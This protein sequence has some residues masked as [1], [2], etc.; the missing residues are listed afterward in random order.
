MM[1]IVVSSS[2]EPL[3]WAQDPYIVMCGGR[4][5]G[6]SEFAGRKLFMRGEQEGGHRFLIVR[7]IRRT[8]ADSV[9][10]L[11]RRILDDNGV[12]YVYNKNEHIITVN[13]PAGPYEFVFV[14]LD[15]PEKIKSFTGMTSAWIEEA[16]ELTRDD[17]LKLDLC[18]REPGPGYHQMMLTFNPQ[19]TEA[20]WLKEMFFGATPYP[21]AL[22]HNSTI[23]D[24]PL[25][26]LDY[27]T[28]AA[29][30]GK[31]DTLKDQDEALWRISR[32]GQWASRFGQIF[33]WDV[34]DLPLGQVDERTGERQPFPFDDVF[35]GGD[36]GYSI[37]PAGLLRISR[38][39]DDFWLEELVYK[40]GLTNQDLS[41]EMVRVGVSK[42]EVSYWD[43]AEPKSIEEL[44]RLGWKALPAT[45]GQ[46][47]VR[48]GIDFLKSKR[49]HIVTGSYNLKKEHDGYCWRKDKGGDLMNEPVA[50]D[51]HLMTAAR[52]GI[53]TRCSRPRPRVWS[54]TWS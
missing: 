6:K 24:N 49:I 2:F 40:T 35:L 19:E 3:L 38:K 53:F 45:K 52:Y 50:F 54:A 12:K 32:L 14:G 23:D 4:G 28:W 29:Y 13:G 17:F 10:F 11:V 44:R 26:R 16:T 33:N 15:D 41:A 7:K 30:A 39:A 36:F 47:S 9:V 25:K 34:Q 31:L 21:G 27:K 51:D 5:S 18:L 43:S 46:D 42:S 20:R 8:C 22:V 1:E 37:D 48:A